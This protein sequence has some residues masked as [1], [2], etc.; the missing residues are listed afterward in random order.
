MLSAISQDVGTLFIQRA[1]RYS[2]FEVEISSELEPQ[3]VEQYGF[4]LLVEVAIANPIPTVL[5][6][7]AKK[8]LSNLPSWTKAFEDSIDSATPSLQEPQTVAGAF[9]NAL[10]NDFPENF[11]R[12]VNL[13]EL[14]RYISTADENQLD[15]IY[16]VS[17]VQASATKIVGDNVSLAKVDTLYDLYNSLSTDYVYY[18]NPVD[19]EIITVKLF[20]NFSVDG[21]VVQ[22]IPTLRW[23]W[24]DEFGAKVGLQ[25]LYLE[26]NSNF[27]KRILDVYANRPGPGKE[28]VQKTLRRELDIWG[29]YGAT[30]DSNYVGATPEI[31]E[32]SDIESSTPY[33]DFAGRPQEEF[34]KFV[35]NINERYPT[36]WGY[37]KWGEGFWDYSGQDQSG[38]GRVPAIYDGSTPLGS[39]YQPG[40]G[41]FDD[42]KLVVK[43]S[44]E[45]SVDFNARL[46]A[47]GSYIVGYEDYY[48][49]VS[50]D[51]E[52]YGSYYKD[53]YE[54]QAATVNFR[55]S[56]VMPDTYTYYTDISVYPRNSYAPGNA[57]SPEYQLV[58]IFDQDGYS[59]SDYVFKRLGNDQIY[60]DSS[61]TPTTNRINVLK[62]NR[63]II[64]AK[65]SPSN[66]LYNL[67]FV[68][69]TPIIDTTNQSATMN[70]SSYYQ[71][72]YNV[73]VS[74]DIYNK[75]RGV[76]TTDKITAT[77][78][79]NRNN[80]SSEPLSF[81]I[82]KDF[83]HQTVVFESEATPIYIHIDNV[84]PSGYIVDPNAYFDPQYEGFGGVSS[85]PTDGLNYL[86]PASP[87]LLIRYENPNFATPTAHDYLAANGGST[88]DYYFVGAKYPYGSTPGTISILTNENNKVIY[89]FEIPIWGSFEEY[90]TPIISGTVNKRGVVRSSSEQYDETYTQ[91]SNH[92]GSYNISYDTFDINPDFYY[93]TKI[94]VENNTPGVEL[95]AKQ[96]FVYPYGSNSVY[97]NSLTQFEN[98]A[99]SP[100]DIEARYTGVYKSSIKTGWY[101]QL[102]ED[103]YI[104][105]TPITEVFSTPGFEISLSHPSRQGAPIIVERFGATPMILRE[106]AF[107]DESNPATPSII[108]KEYILSNKTNNIYLGYEDIYSATV[109][110]TVTGY[111][112]LDNGYSPTNEL[113]VFSEAS[114]SVY[115]REYEV[116]Y[117][118]ANSY[119]VDNDFYDQQKQIYTTKINFDA[120]PSEPYG[121]IVTYES[122][123]NGSSTP[124]SLEVNPMKI[125][126]DE[127]FVYLSH[128]DYDFNLAELKLEPAYILNDGLDYMQL[129]INSLDINGNPKPYQTFRVVSSTA[130][131]SSEY[132]TTDINGF[133][134]VRLTCPSSVVE[135]VGFVS[136]LGV[137]NGSVNAH[138]NS[139]TQG[140]SDSVDFEITNSYSSIY[141]LK[142]SVDRYSIS[143]DGIS[144]IF[145]S[146]I[147]KQSGTPD[148]NRIVYWRKGRDLYSIYSSNVQGSVTTDE[149]GRFTIGPFT[150]E[151]LTP[152]IWFVSVESE[153]SSS[154]SATPSTVS[155]D[156]VYWI[157]KYDSLNYSAGQSEFFNPNVLYVQPNEMLATPNFTINYYDGSEAQTYIATPNWNPPVWYPLNRYTQYQMGLLGSTPNTVTTYVNL[158]K[159]Y[160][161]E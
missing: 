38:V 64:S 55:Y 42:A 137:T 49:P 66:G 15:W 157:E 45:N 117:K 27:R 158:M 161:E 130:I 100:V 65:T 87:N 67:K 13:Y 68:G 148:K 50:V 31:L 74:S 59:Y 82:N 23:N 121:Y 72:Y 101:S 160:E 17:N 79:P 47:L 126:N 7:T 63:A 83:I 106:V 91:N 71:N 77:A 39:Y 70:S 5:G 105:A 94:E 43:E 103:Y 146:G 152:G 69:A 41:D 108:N 125:W 149:N 1:K 90:S 51:Y 118:V 142:A 48:S 86:V 93:I 4:V 58:Q 73:Q 144:Q 37:V 156:I 9:I 44:F 92:L 14:D 131:S 133:A 145:I 159:D 35:R 21:N 30:P 34:R 22:Q 132:V 54:N 102:E 109:V 56:L 61:A 151:N 2:K 115:G 80:V 8:I 136:V 46:K 81:E 20:K 104:Y 155:G 75:K 11:E 40:V 138:E 116:S 120:T 123:I 154:A 95:T 3:D 110:D 153:H 107:Y 143:A 119:I 97:L 25:R 52:Y 113:T 129:V 139:Q 78:Y 147:L 128:N 62:S 135:T 111:T 18:Y 10:V 98:G 6:K 127:G 29:A 89:P 96:E 24:F 84:K 76:F 124:I 12:Q 57:A 112:I 134:A 53:Y 16:T 33:F 19:R 99:F 88:V 32:V 141:E 28:S 122:S 36:N 150:S 140:F 26:T 60:V 85:N 114:P